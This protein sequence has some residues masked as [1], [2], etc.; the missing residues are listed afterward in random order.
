M[1]PP[2]RCASPTAA[3]SPPVQSSSTRRH[4]DG[5]GFLVVRGS[6]PEYTRSYF[7]GIYIPLIFHFG[8]FPVAVVNAD[9]LSGIDF[10][11]GTFSARYGRAFGGTVEARSRRPESDGL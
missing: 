5:L 7:D 4:P 11:A 1:A 2:P 9:A 8:G 6:R 3:P 10:Y